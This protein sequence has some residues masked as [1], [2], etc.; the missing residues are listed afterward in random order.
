MNKND[1]TDQR[2]QMA[3]VAPQETNSVEER[4]QL[5]AFSDD[6]AVLPEHVPGETQLPNFETGQFKDSMLH[7]IISFLERPQLLRS[8]ILSSGQ[9]GMNPSTENSIGYNLLYADPQTKLQKGL[10]VPSQCFTTLQK[11]KL[12]GFAGFRATM[13]FKLQVNSQPM[14]AGRLIMSAVPMP[15]LLNYRGDY[16]AATISNIMNVNHIQID[17]AKQTEIE[18][19]IPF[20]SP[21]NCY[22]LITG[23]FDWARLYI[24]V[25]GPLNVTPETT[26]NIECIL[27]GHFEDIQLGFPTSATMLPQSQSGIV[28]SNISNYK[29]FNVTVAD[30]KPYSDSNSYKGTFLC[31]VNIGANKIK[32]TNGWIQ[33]HIDDSV[34]SYYYK[35]YLDTYS[36]HFVDFSLIVKD[37][38][39]I[40]FSTVGV[41]DAV[42]PADNRVFCTVQLIS[43]NNNSS[44]VNQLD[45]NNK[46][47]PL[48]IEDSNVS[49]TKNV[50]IV[51]QPIQA[52]I[53]N[54]LPAEVSIV[55]QPVWTTPAGPIPQSQSGRF[56]SRIPIRPSR[57]P[58][59]MPPKEAAPAKIEE[60]RK[61]ESDGVF[62]KAARSI[63]A[64][65]IS[66]GTDIVNG[67]ANVAAGIGNLFGWSKPQLSHAGNTVVVRPSQ[68]FGNTDGI[69]HSHVM[70]L[71]VMNNVDSYPSMT[72]T[73]LDECSFEFLKRVPNFIG[74]F[75]Y[76]ETNIDDDVL[77]SWWVCPNYV[78]P[79]KYKL[80]DENKSIVDQVKIEE[81]LP[82]NLGYISSPFTYWTGSIVYTFRFVKTDYHS[83][84]VEF[85]FHPFASYLGATDRYDYV[86]RVVVDL[87][88]NSEVSITIPYVSP[89]QW[90]LLEYD[91][92]KF[93]PFNV[94]NDPSKATPDY[95]KYSPGIFVVRA[96]TPLVCQTNIVAKSVG[97][98]VEC[99][100]GDDYQV[101][102]P[103]HSTYFPYTFTRAAPTPKSQSGVVYAVPG[104]QDTR[105]RALEG[106]TPP[107][108]TGDESDIN[109]PDSQMFT[110]GEV[111]D[112]FRAFTRRFNFVTS[113]DLATNNDTTSYVRYDQ[114]T[115]TNKLLSKNLSINPSVILRPIDF[116]I[117]PQLNLETKT[118]TTINNT[119]V[120]VQSL[121]PRYAPSPLS[122][123]AGMYCFYR[124]GIRFKTCLT[125]KV[126][127]NVYDR[128]LTVAKLIYHSKHDDGSDPDTK[129]DLLS[130]PQVTKYISASGYEIQPLK[131]FAEFQ[132]PYY[133]P[134]L[135]SC[136]W[137]EKAATLY[138]RPQPWLEIANS[139]AVTDEKIFNL[140]I[141]PA[142][143]DD[144]DFG[145][146]IGPPPVINIGDFRKN[147]RIEQVG[148]DVKQNN[149]YTSFSPFNN[150][151]FW[152]ADPSYSLQQATW[153]I[154]GY[155]DLKRDS[156]ALK[157]FSKDSTDAN[158]LLN[159]TYFFE[160]TLG[161]SVTL[162]FNYN[163]IEY[164]NQ[165]ITGSIAGGST[166]SDNSGSVINLEQQTKDIE[167]D[168]L[169]ADLRRQ[170][171]QLKSVAQSQ[172][173]RKAAKQWSRNATTSRD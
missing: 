143:S 2:D 161:K 104:T 50:S 155:Y 134:T 24:Q 67:I 141:A 124:G 101:Q 45:N 37:V 160:T 107:S 93:N 105:T 21:Y 74:Y 135:Q 14:V 71:D 38:T 153:R 159:E 64:K 88:Q 119:K 9:P 163:N 90:K 96:L 114:A 81:N 131:P 106:F 68:Y 49:D 99:R 115:E 149:T 148:K 92:N 154:P 61:E 110:A 76:S 146:F 83:G 84:R 8:F 139:Y 66:T 140:H 42:S 58:L 98:L 57:T 29:G 53:T 34:T 85:S 56:R 77:A 112:N 80:M 166:K 128:S 127:N 31:R 11:R 13:V 87:R 40:G 60:V 144:L 120:D 63:G 19:R 7:S 30:S 41:V 156:N 52:T 39:Y 152:S 65:I 54:P 103:S 82:T 91:S 133:S 129:E 16:V 4:V 15:T 169:I 130:Y 6:M 33:F 165:M 138:D 1:A 72:G 20:I 171:Y 172:A 116:I 113:E 109:R 151:Y 32:V 137:N 111:F 48:V 23:N 123:V 102:C 108:I 94:S 147:L 157:I 27:W 3:E 36:G 69:D 44:I 126:E 167:Q 59:R 132:V 95:L 51:N 26:K 75:N 136:H 100:A 164:N 121:L 43:T 158:P 70:S 150:T 28:T 12:D 118:Y 62:A 17:I 79:F 10:L 25:Y 122:F 97:C 18:L 22:D 89:Q 145:L 47:I 117:P 5:T 168:N 173:A 125:D 162:D 78:Q 142:A 73:D 86:Y 170:V 35:L 46:K 55:N